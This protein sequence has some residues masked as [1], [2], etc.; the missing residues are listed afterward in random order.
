MKKKKKYIY[1]YIYLSEVKIYMMLMMFLFF[2]FLI[3][4][5]TSCSDLFCCY[6]RSLVIDKGQKIRN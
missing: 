3:V 2:F 5:F 1:I 6:F 4:Q